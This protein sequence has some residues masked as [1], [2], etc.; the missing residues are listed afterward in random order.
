MVFTIISLT[1]V[2]NVPKVVPIVSHLLS[3]PAV[4]QAISSA[5][6]TY[7]LLPVSPGITRTLNLTDV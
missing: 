6:K 4:S 5:M 1:S 3:A 2:L 7:A